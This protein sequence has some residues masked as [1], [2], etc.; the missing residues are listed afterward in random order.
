MRYF[1]MIG[2]D[3][4]DEAVKCGKWIF[5][6]VNLIKENVEAEF[7]CAIGKGEKYVRQ[8]TVSKAEQLARQNEQCNTILLEAAQ[9][10]AADLGVGIS[11]VGLMTT[12]VD[13]TPDGNVDIKRTVCVFLPYSARPKGT[14]NVKD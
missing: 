13:K 11:N 3:K 12:E 2:F 4:E 10:C 7:D 5:D 9:Q 14:A 1:V 8:I 6:N